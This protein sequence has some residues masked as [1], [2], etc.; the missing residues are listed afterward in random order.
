VGRLTYAAAQALWADAARRPTVL[1]DGAAW[2]KT[3]AALHFPDATT[4]LDWGHVE[5]AVHK[6]IRAARAGAANRAVRRAAHRAIPAL[7]WHGRLDEAVAARRLLQAPRDDAVPLLDETIRS[8]LGQRGWLGDYAAW[9]EAGE[10]IGSGLVEREVALV[11]NRRMKRQG[12]RW[13][14]ANADAV[15]A[16]RVRTINQSWDQNVA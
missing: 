6:A 9:Q 3:Q 2:I 16:L 15:A 13:R 7:L 11:I 5:R 1:G 14:R 12:M 8:L 10:Q 4:I